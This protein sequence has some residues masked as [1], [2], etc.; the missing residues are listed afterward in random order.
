MQLSHVPGP[1]TPPSS[2]YPVCSGWIHSVCLSSWKD[3]PVLVVQLWM[4][5]L[6]IQ[7]VANFHDGSRLR[8]VSPSEAQTGAALGAPALTGGAQWALN[9][10]INLH[11]GGFESKGGVCDWR[12]FSGNEV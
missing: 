10:A 8:T 7:P 12:Y 1:R 5:A 9:A 3:G 4:L 11:R 2:S 6:E